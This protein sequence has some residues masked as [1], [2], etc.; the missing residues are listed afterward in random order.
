MGGARTRDQVGE[1]VGRIR[2]LAV[3]QNDLRKLKPLSR[4]VTP[5]SR[6]SIKDF[7]QV[8]R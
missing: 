3:F 1:E 6:F 8:I 7:T 5:L 2:R 4:L